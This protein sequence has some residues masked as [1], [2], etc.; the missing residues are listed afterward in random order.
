ML[1]TEEKKQ[2]KVDNKKYIWPPFTRIE[3]Y[4]NLG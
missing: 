4:L 2:L 1:S 3:D